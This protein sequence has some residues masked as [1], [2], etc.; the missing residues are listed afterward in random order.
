MR[1]WRVAAALALV[2]SGCATAPLAPDPTVNLWGQWKIVAVDGQPTG[3]SR[4]FN[5]EL[6]PTYGVAQ[7]G[8]NKGSG[9]YVIRDG[10]FVGGDHWIITAASCLNREDWLDFEHKGF[11][12]LSKPLAIERRAN[13]AIRLRNRLGSI[14]LRRP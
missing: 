9:S 3:A 4:N 11:N 13:G 14:K 2:A 7:F 1:L 8:C 12:I 6:N 5:F 10:W